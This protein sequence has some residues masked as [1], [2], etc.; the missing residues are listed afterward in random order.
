MLCLKRLR[1]FNISAP[2]SDK[3]ASG[4]ALTD[5]AVNILETAS[6]RLKADLA[7]DLAQQWSA[8]GIASLE[9][10]KNPPDRPSRPDTPLLLLPRDMPKR[11]AGGIPG[12]IAL[13]HAVAHIELNA[14]DLAFDM[15]ARFS[16]DLG[17]DAEAFATDWL[18]V[19]AEEA[20]HFLLV[21]SCLADY[22][23]K[24]GDLPAHDGLW[25]AAAS[26]KQDLMGRLAVVP[27]VLEARGLDVTP[28]MI[29][30]FERYGDQH[31]VDALKTIY[32][33]EVGHVQI[34]TKWFI[35]LC[36][37]QKQEPIAAF[38]K[39]VSKYFKGNLKPPFNDSARM[40]AG[41]LPQFYQNSID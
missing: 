4:K 14:I 24:Y 37:S 15:I 8:G 16:G 5:G 41:L 25:E 11:R 30:K 34:G 18:R 12:R 2:G 32:R 31:A 33:E 22:D 3:S 40:E 13:L 9:G 36:Q 26:T 39:L 20:K 19:G 35:R 21:E 29:E 23:A 27:M 7:R 17:V 6:P 28:D 38:K 1:S 10:A